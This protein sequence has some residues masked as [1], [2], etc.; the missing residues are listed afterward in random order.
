MLA[1]GGAG[2]RVR[3][4]GL[5]RDLGRNY[6]IPFPSDPRGVGSSPAARTPPQRRGEG[7]HRVDTYRE[8]SRRD[9]AALG[10]ICGINRAVS[11]P[12]RSLAGRKTGHD[13]SGTHPGR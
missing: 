11:D 12:R 6:L 13:S 7:V 5:K 8:R 4:Y 10:G 2:E 9:W 3:R 1:R